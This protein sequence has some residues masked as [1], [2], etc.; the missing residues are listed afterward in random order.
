MSGMM[1]QKRTTPFDTGLTITKKAKN[2]ESSST[3]KQEAM[4]SEREEGEGGANGKEGEEDDQDGDTLPVLTPSTLME[5]HD[6]EPYAELIGN[7]DPV[8]PFIEMEVQ[9]SCCLCVPNLPHNPA[10]GISEVVIDWMERIPI[11]NDEDAFVEEVF[12]RTV[13]WHYDGMGPS[14]SGIISLLSLAHRIYGKVVEIIKEDNRTLRFAVEWEAT[15][16]VY[17]SHI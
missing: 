8:A 6:D 7:I 11:S 1:S 17:G 4:E 10:A 2:N 15:Q 3:Y 13:G 9:I 16:R 12:I 14:A 5:V